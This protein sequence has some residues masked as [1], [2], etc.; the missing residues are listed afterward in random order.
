MRLPRVRVRTL[1]IAVAVL[2]VLLAGCLEYRRLTRLSAQY[3][4]LAWGY[5][6]NVRMRLRNLARAK[7]EMM[8]LKEALNWDVREIQRVGI[9]I[10][11]LRADIAANAN[12]VQIYE[13]AANHPW[14]QR[15]LIAE[16]GDS[17]ENA[18]IPKRILTSPATPPP[19]G[20]PDFSARP[21]ARLPAPSTPAPYR[22]K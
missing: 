18:P 4:F 17:V 9:E 21:A 1:L 3:R 12:L 22:S 19:P 14:E 7:Q 11:S 20:P 2:A 5:G 15:P 10:E 8:E 6:D 16:A 13:H